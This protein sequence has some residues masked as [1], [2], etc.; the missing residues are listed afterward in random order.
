MIYVL[1][2]YLLGCVLV[3]DRREASKDAELLVLRHE[4]A[5]LR[6]RVSRVRYQPVGLEY[7]IVEVTCSLL[8]AV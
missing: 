8:V 1:V 6:R 7:T 3:A 5:V 2:R 4:N